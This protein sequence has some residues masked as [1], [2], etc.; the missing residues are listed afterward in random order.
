MGTTNTALI[1]VV[2][3]NLKVREDD[4]TEYGTGDDVSSLGGGR[5]PDRAPWC[6]HLAWENVN[7][8]FYSLLRRLMNT[9]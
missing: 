7:A 9:S 2:T 3:G 1:A 8:T 4:V 6:K 5:C